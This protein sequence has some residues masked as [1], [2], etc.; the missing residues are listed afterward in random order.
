MDSEAAALLPEGH[1]EIA[2]VLARGGLGMVYRG[3]DL[4]T[5]KDVVLK[6]LYL[7]SPEA[8]SRTD[9]E[10][11]LSKQLGDALNI[12]DFEEGYFSPE[13]GIAILVYEWINGPSLRTLI[14]ANPNG[15]PKNVAAATA[16]QM[17]QGLKYLH[18]HGVIHRDIKPDNVLITEQGTVK[19]S[20]FGIAVLATHNNVTSNI[21]TRGSF[22]G[23]LRYAAPEMVNNQLYGPASDIYALGMTILEMLG[24]NPFPD[25]SVFFLLKEIMNGVVVKELPQ[26]LKEEWGGLLL[27]A[28]DVQPD[29]RPSADALLQMLE[30]TFPAEGSSD[31]AII[32][33]FLRAG[34]FLR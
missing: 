18:Q 21:T 14:N 24:W 33:D 34:E 1:Y 19:L 26:G 20:D 32:T 4:L 22:V 10:I 5:G 9:R 3:R 8:L 25:S 16:R 23:T 28:L 2:K 15:L 31:E 17:C 13:A 27:P 7:T 30:K 11:A 6:C 12:V 29:R